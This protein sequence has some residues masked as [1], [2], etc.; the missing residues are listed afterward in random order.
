MSLLIL[1]ITGLF[2]YWA[3]GLVYTNEGNSLV[4]SP[5]QRNVFPKISDY[6][7]QKNGFA[8]AVGVS[9]PT[10]FEGMDTD[11]LLKVGLFVTELEVIGGT[12]AGFKHTIEMEPCT[13]KNFEAFHPAHPD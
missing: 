10:R 5:P 11:D 9:T 6:Y 8:F 12:Y 2:T 7:G 13:D 4:W 3:V 1:A